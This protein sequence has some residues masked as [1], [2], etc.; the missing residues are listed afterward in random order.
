MKLANVKSLAL[1]LILIGTSISVVYLL[2]TFGPKGGGSPPPPSNET[3][4]PDMASFALPI[5]EIIKIET[6]SY[7]LLKFDAAKDMN[8]TGAIRESAGM[9]IN[10]LILNE[11]NMRNWLNNRSFTAYARANSIVQYN[12][13]FTT[14]HEGIYYCVFD[15]REMFVH[16]PCSSKVVIFNLKPQG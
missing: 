11:T 9:C 1:A 7:Y 13:T 14:D 2:S 4:I 6:E 5:S 10:F 8:L 15:N 16:A 3:E 12:F